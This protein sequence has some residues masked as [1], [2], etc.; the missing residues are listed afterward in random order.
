M[1]EALAGILKAHFGHDAF[2]PG[3]DR[4][5]Q[6]I[7]AGRSTLAVMPTGA[8]KSLCYQLPALVFQGV[9][10]VVSP[11]IALIRD[12]VQALTRAGIPAAA[13][14]SQESG[15][16]RSQNL[17]ALATGR[18]K[19]AYVAP[20]RFRSR[21]FLEALRGVPLELFAVD[22]AHCIAEWGHDFRPDY[23]R[24]GEVIRDLSPRR[25]LGLTATATPEVR[26]QIATSLGLVDPEVVVTGFDRAEL[27]L[28]VVETTRGKAKIEALERTLQ[29][30]M[31]P[32]GSAIVYVGTRKRAEATAQIL[33]ERGFAAEAYHAG[34]EPEARARVERTFKDG[35]SRVVVATNAFGMG[36][37]KADVRV[38]AHAQIP[39][40][41]EA[42]YQEVGRAGRDGAKAAGVL[43]YDSADLRLA[44]TRFL[45][46]C[47]THAAVTAAFELATYAVAEGPPNLES[48][49]GRVEPVVGPSARAAVVALLQAGDLSFERGRLEVLVPATTVSAEHLETR[50]R[51]ERQRLD[52]MIGYVSRAAC[53]RRYL[54]DYFGDARRPERCGVCD[55]CQRPAPQA[56][57]GVGRRDALIAL[58]CVAR[59]RGRYGKQR[60]ADVLL[61]SRAKPILS[62][63]LDTLSTHGLL[64]GLTK[65]DTLAL[66]DALIR[67]DLARIAPG[68]FPKLLLTERGVGVLKDKEATVALDLNLSRWAAPPPSIEKKDEPSAD[69]QALFERLRTWRVEQARAHGVPPYVVAH[70][71]LLRAIAS[72]RPRTLEV[73]A[74]LPGVGR[75]KLE[76]YGA[77][78][79]ALVEGLPLPGDG[80]VGRESVVSQVDSA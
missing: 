53:R 24:L 27:Q 10:L 22:E 72:T 16:E 25:V 60:V 29:T 77:Q 30:W 78:L 79:L 65:E 76:R 45:A 55:R 42:Y 52:A 17:E 75:T 80:P 40:A 14:T 58:S 28:K 38:V 11:L 2:R 35:Q 46:S 37:D 31:G 6:S 59:M 67:A 12:Q 7:L 26:T 73:L 47:P 68:D 19:L 62:A 43:L 20:E 64:K 34:L 8:G 66:L 54:V 51:H 41:P 69:D 50:A 61:G 1:T 32:T 13:I 21:A 57:E 74:E 36:V 5:I 4:V 71:R 3:Q 39:A 15:R 9:T 33:A 44:Y 18:I 48:L 70:D 49:V 63:K 56:L 23:A